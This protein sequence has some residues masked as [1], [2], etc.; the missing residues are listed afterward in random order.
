VIR[1]YRYRLYPTRAQKVSLDE[2]TW[3]LREFY[4]AV[5][6][7]RREAYRKQ[8]VSIRAKDQ[9]KEIA[10][11]R[12]L[13]PEYAAIHWH[14]LQDVITRCDRA[15]KAFFRRLK[16]GEK[17][18][19]PRFKGRNRYRTFTFKDAANRNGVR[20]TTGGKRVEIAGIGSVKIKMHRSMEGTLKQASVT[21]G[22]DG[23]WYIAFACVDVPAK[24]LPLTG[25]EVG[26]DL[27]ITTF[28]AL[29]N[30]DDIQ[31]PR[32]FE[33]AQAKLA[34]ANRRV[35]RGK[36]YSRR[37]RKAV[38]LLAKHHARVARIRLDF[39]HKAARYLVVRYES[40]YLEDLNIKGLA[41]GF[42]A[43]Q[44]HDAAWGQFATILSNKAECAG[45]W[46]SR[47]DPRGTSIECSECHERV[48][49]ALGDRVHECPYCGL[50]INRDTNAAR[51]TKSRGQRD[52]EALGHAP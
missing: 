1:V 45:R 32:P 50:V 12:E 7:H 34:S 11:I 13:R 47:S 37:R 22:G 6:E 41:K 29:D 51:N 23:H 3:R 36:K 27:G 2:L 21:L 31:N 20:L 10:G 18:G 5:L 19:Y 4:N 26:V 28:A 39:H 48:P 52:R 24:P 17:P 46:F 15:F 14:L 38:A 8:R 16:A 9:A 25:Q 44:V 40:L 42:L 30:G 43:K 33:R 35:A 49:K